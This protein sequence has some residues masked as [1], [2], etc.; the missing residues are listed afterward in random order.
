MSWESADFIS[1][2]QII[3][4]TS[5]VPSFWVCQTTY[6]Y[7]RPIINWCFSLRTRAFP[8]LLPG[9]Q[10]AQVPTPPI[11][12]HKGTR[13]LM[14]AWPLKGNIRKVS[15]LGK[16]F[17]ECSSVASPLKVLRKLHHQQIK[18]S[19]C[20]AHEQRRLVLFTLSAKEKKK[21]EKKW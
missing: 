1:S 20:Q 11:L 4:D 21:K 3:K 2:S 15:G 6:S 17:G 13:T 8:K 18:T 10:Y 12:I 9:K 16:V 5:S 7:S 19:K 14:T